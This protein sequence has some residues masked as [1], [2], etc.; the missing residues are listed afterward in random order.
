MSACSA[1]PLPHRLL[2]LSV[3]SVFAAAPLLVRGVVAAPGPVVCSRADLLSRHLHSV[4]PSLPSSPDVLPVDLPSQ[5]AGVADAVAGIRIEGSHHHSARSAAKYRRSSQALQ[6]DCKRSTRSTGDSA[7]HDRQA[8]VAVAGSRQ[9][10]DE[11][12]CMHALPL[13]SLSA[14]IRRQDWTTPEKLLY[15]EKR[16]HSGTD[17]ARASQQRARPTSRWILTRGSLCAR[18][19]HPLSALLRC[20]RRYRLK[21]GSLQQFLPT[22]R[23]KEETLV[24]EGLTLRAW[25]LGG[26][27]AARQMWTRYAAMADA[28]IFMVDAADPERLPEAAQE[29]KDLLACAEMAEVPV[30]I[31]AN[32]CE[33]KVREATLR[34]NRASPHNAPV[35]APV[36]RPCGA[37]YALR[38]KSLL[39]CLLLLCCPLLSVPCLPS[40]PSLSP[41]CNPA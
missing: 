17:S 35:H 41:R 12:T 40:T 33:L 30:A 13:A 24:V 15:S 38:S 28:A 16:A 37:W 36:P 18:R 31:F 11:L 9:R 29:L 5:L 39:H 3:S 8:T 21:T 2:R 25:D 4:I 32:K 27:L 14:L 20:A 7:A 10:R 23:A 26:H 22:Q 34:P 1:P 19:P 6:S